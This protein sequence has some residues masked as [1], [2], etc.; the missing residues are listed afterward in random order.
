[1]ERE[2]QGYYL[3]C[4]TGPE[5]FRAFIPQALPPVPP[6][7]LD[8]TLQDL[9]ERANRALGRL[10]GIT[11]LLP[12]PS[13][14]L[15]L[16]IRKEALLSSQIE[17]TKSSFSDLLLYESEETPGVPLDD[18]QQVSCYI[19]ALNHGLSRLRT[20]FPLCMR[21]LCEIHE[22]LLQEGRGSDQFPG[23]IRTSQNWIGGTRPGNAT[24]VPPPPHEVGNSL[25]DFENFL[26]DI[27]QRTPVL[28]KAALTHVQFESIHPFSDGNGRLGRLLITFLLCAEGALSEPLLY[29][30]LYFKTHRSLYYELLQHVRV[31]GD[32]EA[33]LK[34]FLEGVAVTAEQA[35]STAR[36]ILSVFEQDRQRI[37]NIGRAAGSTL[38]LH[39]LMRKKPL[40]SITRAAD[41]LGLTRPTIVSCVKHL[42]QLGIIAETT[43]R[44]RD[45]TF[46]YVDYLSILNEGTE[47]L[48][49]SKKVRDSPKW[50]Y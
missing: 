14:F 3:P 31:R 45:R 27:P 9:S 33:W 49:E 44:R 29:L 18:V 10:D 24:F 39:Q 23:E 48:Q 36:R 22:V 35:S 32:W 46:I 6:L 37:E 50:Q 47:P 7:H 5:T 20:G 43:G 11:T 8:S 2:I 25:K 19:S 30:S 26:H 41:D 1:M 28:I 13:L 15:Y 38:R 21:L 42:E 40:F 17:G 16:Y 4:T 34:F 12:E